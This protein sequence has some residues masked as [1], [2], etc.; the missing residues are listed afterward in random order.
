VA[1]DPI[2]GADPLHATASSAQ[3]STIIPK[4]FAIAGQYPF[5]VIIAA[6]RESALF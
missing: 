5:N 2:A 1:R 3:S 6:F 4:V